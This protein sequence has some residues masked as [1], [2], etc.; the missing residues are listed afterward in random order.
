MDD[1]QFLLPGIRQQRHWLDDTERR[2]AKQEAQLGEFADAM[3][4]QREERDR[5]EAEHVA[6]EEKALAL[7]TEARDLSARQKLISVWALVVS[8]LA[9]AVAAVAVFVGG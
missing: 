9:L 6:R 1:D 5:K 4:T 7:A 8:I 2:R 3:Q